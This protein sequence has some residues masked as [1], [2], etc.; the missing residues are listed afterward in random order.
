MQWVPWVETVTQTTTG[1]PSADAFYVEPG[2]YRSVLAAS[3]H[4]E[5]A[6]KDQ[7]RDNVC[8]MLAGNTACKQ[9]ILCYCCPSLVPSMPT[10]KLEE[11]AA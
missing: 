6:S 4:S 9:V 11:Q 5:H 1:T 8:S 2:T 7:A 10:V 3:L